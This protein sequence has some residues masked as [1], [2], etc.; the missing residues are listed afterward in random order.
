MG[1]GVG[2]G[3]KQNINVR[4]QVMVITLCSSTAFDYARSLCIGKTGQHIL[5]S[6]FLVASHGA[7]V[8]QSPLAICPEQVFGRMQRR[9]VPKKSFC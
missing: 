2:Q 3:R 9:G 1:V 4:Q 7:F 8:V 6:V 5:P